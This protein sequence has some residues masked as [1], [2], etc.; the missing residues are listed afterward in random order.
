MQSDLFF[1]VEFLNWN[2]LVYLFETGL[3][4]EL[5]VFLLTYYSNSFGVTVWQVTGDA[6]LEIYIKICLN[7]GINFVQYCVN[8]TLVHSGGSSVLNLQLT[9]INSQEFQNNNLFTH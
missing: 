2:F 3:I 4:W 6:F 1:N 8:F 5:V 9:T 7:H